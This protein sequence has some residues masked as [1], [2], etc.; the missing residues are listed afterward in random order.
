MMWQNVFLRQVLLQNLSFFENYEDIEQIRIISP[1]FHSFWAR[2][3]SITKYEIFKEN[4][5]H[6]IFKNWCWVIVNPHVT[7]LLF[8]QSQVSLSQ[9]SRGK[10]ILVQF[11]QT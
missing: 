9:V 6:R 8:W 10:I 2:K 4:T 1:L 7:L 5:F 3:V 11:V